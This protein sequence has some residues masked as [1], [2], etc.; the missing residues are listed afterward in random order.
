MILLIPLSVFILLA[1]VYL[2]RRSDFAVRMGIL[3]IVAIIIPFIWPL[4]KL[5]WPETEG[6]KLNLWLSKKYRDDPEKEDLNVL[7][8]IYGVGSYVAKVILC[9]VTAQ[10][11]AAHSFKAYRVFMVGIIYFIVQFGFW[12]WNKNTS[13]YANIIVYLFALPLIIYLLM[14][15]K[16]IVRSIEDYD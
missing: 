11:A 9:Y 10:F 13:V 6:I 8:Y 16:A 1:V 7:W 3:F 14:P 2:Y 15:D 12:L 5:G 4:V